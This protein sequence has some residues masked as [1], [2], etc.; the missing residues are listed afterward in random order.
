MAGSV[1]MS[2]KFQQ[3]A[4]STNRFLSKILGAA[5]INHIRWLQK[6]TEAE[7]VTRKADTAMERAGGRPPWRHMSWGP[8]RRAPRSACNLTFRLWW[9]FIFD[10]FQ[11][12]P[13]VFSDPLSWPLLF[14][15]AVFSGFPRPS[16]RCYSSKQF[17]S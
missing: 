12:L 8:P 3:G 1:K 5:S 9:N 11:C 6:L 7:L 2:Q 15:W 10:C 13:W 4:L 16:F 14:S 17:I